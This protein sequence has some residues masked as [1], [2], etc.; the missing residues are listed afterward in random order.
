MVFCL[1]FGFFSGNFISLAPSILVT[2]CPNL[3]VFGVRLGMLFVPMAIGPLIGNPIAGAVL[4]HGWVALQA[5]CG[6]TTV[7]AVL[8]ALALRI[9]KA[10]I[11]LKAKT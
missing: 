6:A 3:G 11:R 8:L 9:M 1:L 4:D 5:F 7:F 10:G 2:L